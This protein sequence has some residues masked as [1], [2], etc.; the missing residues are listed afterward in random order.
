VLLPFRLA[1]RLLVKITRQKKLF[2]GILVD[3]HHLLERINDAQN[4]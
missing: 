3:T 2:P 1:R 4:E